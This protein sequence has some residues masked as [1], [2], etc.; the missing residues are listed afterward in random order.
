MCFH[1]G[2]EVVKALMSRAVD[3]SAVDTSPVVSDGRHPSEGQKHLTTFV[4]LASRLR[5]FI[6]AGVTGKWLLFILWACLWEMGDTSPQYLGQTPLRKAGT[7][8]GQTYRLRARQLS[9][10]ASFPDC[11][12]DCARSIRAISIGNKVIVPVSL[13]QTPWKTSLIRSQILKQ[14]TLR[15]RIPQRVVSAHSDLSSICF[16]SSIKRAPGTSAWQ[17]KSK[18]R[19]LSMIGG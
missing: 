19:R 2:P 13:Y 6:L 15:T 7:C 8:A 17:P 10:C 16:G 3:K 5:A 14:Q 18:G 11:R 12:H 9:W 1:I 4:H